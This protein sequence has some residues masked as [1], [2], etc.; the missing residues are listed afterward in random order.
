M[1]PWRPRLGGS[2]QR[3]SHMHGD[4]RGSDEIP[5]VPV[6]Y[7]IQGAAPPEHSKQPPRSIRPAA[8]QIPPSRL[9][10]PSSRPSPGRPAAGRSAGD[11]GAAG[12]GGLEAILRPHATVGVGHEAG[13]RFDPNHAH[14][15]GTV[16]RFGR[17]R[18]GASSWRT[19]CVVFRQACFHST[20][21]APHAKSEQSFL[22]TYDETRSSRKAD[23][24]KGQLSCERSGPE[25]V[26]KRSTY[27]SRIVLVL[28][29]G[30]SSA[31]Q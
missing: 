24:A 29:F 7:R 12:I 23:T 28:G 20:K 9:P 17:E 27:Q 3:M 16:V 2:P 30:R 13:R 11:D 31:G 5:E 19:L 4:I 18:G 21:N 10:V 1:V 15:C 26:V 8:L 25:R 14:R 22:V 6:R